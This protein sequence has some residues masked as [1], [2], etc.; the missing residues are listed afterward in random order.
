VRDNKVKFMNKIID[1]IIL[2]L[3]L[4]IWYIL[5]AKTIAK[6]DNKDENTAKNMFIANV[7]LPI[8]TYSSS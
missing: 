1:I 5:I 7:Y 2:S 8:S 4:M 6:I 3:H